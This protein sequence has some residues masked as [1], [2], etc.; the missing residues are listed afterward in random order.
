MTNKKI[1]VVDDI[2]TERLHLKKILSKNGFDVIET[3]NGAEAVE[4]VKKHKPDAVLMD[5]VM[6]EFNGF[7]ATRA[8]K[9]DPHTQAI[10]VIMVTSK[11]RAPDKFNAKRVKANAFIVKPAKEAELLKVLQAALLSPEKCNI[12]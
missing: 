2:A 1:L 12:D 4:A 10:P 6:G 11:D 3:E 7:E 8:I 9:E 5:V